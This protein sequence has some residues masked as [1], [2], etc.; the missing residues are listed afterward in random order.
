LRGRRAWDRATGRQTSSTRV[1][2]RPKEKGWVNVENDRRKPP[3]N[4]IAVLYS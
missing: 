2:N 3:E 1:R 4:R